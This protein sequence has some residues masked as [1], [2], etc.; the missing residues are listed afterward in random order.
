[1]AG[2]TDL[3]NILTG[4]KRAQE[5][6]RPVVVPQKNTDV[7]MLQNTNTQ[8]DQGRRVNVAIPE[9]LHKSLRLHAVQTDQQ[10]REVVEAALKEYLERAG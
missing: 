1:V 7:L 5:V 8:T 9:S 3:E 6:E 2:K 4:A 10:L